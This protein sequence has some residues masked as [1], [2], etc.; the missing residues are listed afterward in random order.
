MEQL[1]IKDLQ[2]K[3]RNIGFKVSESE[4]QQLDEFCSREQITI[5]DFIRYTIRIV[6]NKMEK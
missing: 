3:A 1:K 5:T 4:R 6:I 2:K